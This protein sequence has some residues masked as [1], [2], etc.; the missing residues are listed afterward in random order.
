VFSYSFCSVLWYCGYIA[1][2]AGIVVLIS[3]CSLFLFKIR[4][5]EELFHVN[6]ADLN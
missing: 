4:H 3:V 2:G 6:T 5:R 1:D